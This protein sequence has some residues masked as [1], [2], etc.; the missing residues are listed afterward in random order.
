MELPTDSGASCLC[1][2]FLQPACRPCMRALA[3]LRVHQSCP[4]MIGL[5]LVTNY[6]AAIGSPGPSRTAAHDVLGRGRCA[7]ARNPSP[8]THYAESPWESARMHL[9]V[10]RIGGNEGGRT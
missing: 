8:N 3:R 4:R 9:V 7:V 10:G 2:P 6:N 1:Q 5:P